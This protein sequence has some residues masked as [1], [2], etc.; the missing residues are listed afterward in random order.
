MKYRKIRVETTL[1][2]GSKVY[3]VIKGK[4]DMDKIKRFFNMLDLLDEDENTSNIMP[5]SSL[6]DKVKHLIEVKFNSEV[7]TLSDFYRVYKQYFMEAPKKSTL[8]T[9]LTRLVDEGF[10][11]RQGYRGKYAYKYI[12]PVIDIKE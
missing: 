11:I 10:L 6:Y 9:Y 12:K 5:L 8:A 1:S 3:F 4:P 2:D 7:F